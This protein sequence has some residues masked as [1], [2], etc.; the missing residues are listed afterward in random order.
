MATAKKH[1]GRNHFGLKPLPK[2][3]IFWGLDLAGLS[4]GGEAVSSSEKPGGKSP[5]GPALSP[6]ECHVAV[7][8]QRLFIRILLAG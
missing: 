1:H 6:A 7:L 2:F 8:A 5:L 3:T 4:S